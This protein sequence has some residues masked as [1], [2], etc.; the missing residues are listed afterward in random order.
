MY[1]SV[2]PRTRP[3]DLRR[4]RDEFERGVAE[5]ALSEDER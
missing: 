1:G 4:L 2:Q 3:E 5:E